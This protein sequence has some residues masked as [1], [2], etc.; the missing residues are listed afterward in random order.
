MSYVRLLQSCVCACARFSSQAV[1]MPDGP[2]QSEQANS[3]HN[4]V[5]MVSRSLGFAFFLC[6]R[7]VGYL[8]PIRLALQSASVLDQFNICPTRAPPHAEK[9]LRS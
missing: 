7:Y 3:L 1:Q 8:T 4:R 9:L 5:L 6:L 2:A